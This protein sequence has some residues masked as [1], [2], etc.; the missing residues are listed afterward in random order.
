M[1]LNPKILLEEL[2]KPPYKAKL[3]W[4]THIERKIELSRADE[5]GTI[6]LAFIIDHPLMA[7]VGTSCLFSHDMRFIADAMD[8]AYEA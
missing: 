7:T 2:N 3:I 4:T 5:P 1:R 6:Q 8:K